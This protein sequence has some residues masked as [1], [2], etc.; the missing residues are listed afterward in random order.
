MATPTRMYL[1]RLHQGHPFLVE[2]ISKEQAVQRAT[3]PLIVS[4][5]IPTPLETIRL[6]HDGAVMLLAAQSEPTFTQTS[7]DDDDSGDELQGDGTGEALPPA[8]D[9][10]GAQAGEEPGAPLQ[11]GLAEVLAPGRKGKR[12]K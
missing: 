5:T 4:V 9:N 11:D 6:Q 3:A 7:G 2:A 1:V 12:S 8:E 10:D